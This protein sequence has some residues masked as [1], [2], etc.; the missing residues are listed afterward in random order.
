MMAFFH[1][2]GPG[3][4][5]TLVLGLFLLACAALFALRTERHLLRV[6][7]PLGITTFGSAA[8]N[9]CT[10]LIA[11]FRYISHMP[12]GEQF[13]IACQGVEESLH[14]LVLAFIIVTLASLLIT[15]GAWRSRSLEAASA[16]A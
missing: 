11:T 13:S 12:A 16:T 5:L 15:I 8:L 10:G 9:F 7:I 6:A 3:M 4:W 1:E 14:N 2:G